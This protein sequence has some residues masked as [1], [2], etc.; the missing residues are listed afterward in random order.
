VAAAVSTTGQLFLGRNRAS[1]IH[2]PRESSKPCLVA[3]TD[4]RAVKFHGYNSFY[5]KFHSK[6]KETAKQGQL[7]HNNITFAQKHSSCLCSIHNLSH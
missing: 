1:I 2:H 6:K 7:G 3:K 4:A 5:T